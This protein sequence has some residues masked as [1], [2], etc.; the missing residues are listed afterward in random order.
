MTAS[1]PRTAG[2]APL[3]D[4]LNGAVG[5]IS[6]L[7]VAQG[8]GHR[9]YN[10]PAGDGI[11]VI[12]SDISASPKATNSKNPTVES[13]G[14]TGAGI[15]ILAGSAVST[16]LSCSSG[17]YQ[18]TFASTAGL[19]AGGAI[20]CDA[21]PTGTTVQAVSGT[22]VTLSQPAS[23]TATDIAVSTTGWASVAAAI[24]AIFGL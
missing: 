10:S 5:A 21:F 9:V 19:V 24:A 4:L 12:G 3:V 2:A 6:G 23:S 22:T 11:V 14:L 1:P 18:A 7:S 16:T 15:G 8:M 17:L 13:T 20:V